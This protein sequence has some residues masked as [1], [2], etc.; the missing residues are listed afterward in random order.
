MRADLSDGGLRRDDVI[1]AEPL[2]HRDA[3]GDALDGDD[4]S[5]LVHFRSGGHAKADRALRE[6]RDTR[7]LRS[8]LR[9][10]WQRSRWT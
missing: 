9:A 2:R 5:G 3:L 6:D 8:C 10:R 1:G 4:E 7:R